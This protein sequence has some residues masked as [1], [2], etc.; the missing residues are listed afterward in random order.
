LDNLREPEVAENP[1]S[2]S[3]DQ[4]NEQREGIFRVLQN[5]I[6]WEV[7]RIGL[8][9]AFGLYRKRSKTMQNWG[10]LD[11]NPAIVDIGCGIGQYSDV[12]RGNYVGIDLAKNFIDYASKRRRKNP[13]ARFVCDDAGTL[14]DDGSRFDIVLM[15]D[16]LHHLS[17][18]AGARLLDLAADLSQKYIVSFEPVKDQGN[19]FGQWFI[20]HDRGRYIYAYDELRAMFDASPLTIVESIPLKLGFINSR[21]ILAKPK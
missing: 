4:Y 12:T 2:V 17:E 19:P 16:V 21:A 5:P 6:I 15:V 3:P 13:N 7:S 18:G 9:L 14:V 1:D 10:L 20:D 8:D 11:D